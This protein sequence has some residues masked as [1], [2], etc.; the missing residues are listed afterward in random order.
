MFPT[1]L[2]L[3]TALASSFSI[4][5]ADESVQQVL[6]KMNSTLEMSNYQGTFVFMNNGSVETMR[7]IHS[8]SS[9]GV[10]EKLVSL[11]GDAREVIQNIDTNR[12]KVSLLTGEYDYSAT[13]AMTEAA[14][15]LIAGCRFTVMENIGHFPMI[16]HYERFRPYLMTELEQM[17]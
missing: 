13:P 1:R 14:A 10:K 12:C 16:E 2:L 3:I 11:T 15:Q 8:Y 6:N 5:Y 4:A 7:I 9:D 17:L